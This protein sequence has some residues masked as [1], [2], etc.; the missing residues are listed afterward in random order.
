MSPAPR[1]EDVVADLHRPRSTV[2]VT[3]RDRLD[4]A[5]ERFALWG[6]GDMADLAVCERTVSKFTQDRITWAV[7]CA[8]PGLLALAMRPVSVFEWLT[9]PTAIAATVVGGVARR[10]WDSVCNFARVAVAGPNESNTCRVGSA[11]IVPR[12]AD[13][14]SRRRGNSG[15]VHC[16][17]ELNRV[18]LLCRQAIASI[19]QRESIGDPGSLQQCLSKAKPLISDANQLRAIGCQHVQGLNDA[20]VEF[21]VVK[22]SLAIAV[23]EGAQRLREQ[24]AGALVDLFGE[25]M[26]QELL[27]AIADPAARLF[28]SRRGQRKRFE[29]AAQTMGQI[30]RRIDQ[31]TVEVERNEPLLDQNTRVAISAGAASSFSNSPS[32]FSSVSDAPAI[33]SEVQYSPM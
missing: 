5:G 16:C 1:L 9:T 29:R 21:A 13:H 8:A 32:S 17:S 15:P 7:L 14:H 22:Y 31:S 23:I 6:V 18:R 26:V 10:S 25:R 24:V 3:R 11:P 20:R 19:N 30:R 33:S 28:Q 27:N 2:K 4:A 12:I